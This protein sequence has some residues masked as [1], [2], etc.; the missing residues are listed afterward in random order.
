MSW[1][2]G[3]YKPGEVIKRIQRLI[4]RTLLE[5]GE[6]VRW[7]DEVKK[8]IDVIQMMHG[9]DDIVLTVVIL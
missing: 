8:N 2:E 9:L 4:T 7:W 5:T 1:L 6:T 3:E